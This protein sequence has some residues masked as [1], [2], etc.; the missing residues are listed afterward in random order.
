[1]F[2]KKL[3]MYSE[4]KLYEANCRIAAYN[5]AVQEFED[6]IDLLLLLLTE[7]KRRSPHVLYRQRSVDGAYNVLVDRYLMDDDT[8]FREYFRLTP[9]LFSSVLALIKDDLDGIPTNWV[10]KPITAHQKLCIT[11]R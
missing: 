1:M 8:K 5:R 3:E 11:L 7:K 10:Q 6:D 2:G 9:H 4:E